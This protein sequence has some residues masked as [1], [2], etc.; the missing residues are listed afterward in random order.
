MILAVF[1]NSF[2][3]EL[4]RMAFIFLFG[5]FTALMIRQ[6]DGI[7]Y[8]SSFNCD[9]IGSTFVFYALTYYD[10]DDLQAWCVF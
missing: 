5:Y 3:C 8:A 4:I 1:I 10:I 6:H 9:S 2:Y 7:F